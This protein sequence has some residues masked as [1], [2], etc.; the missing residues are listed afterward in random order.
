LGTVETDVPETSVAAGE[1]SLL[2]HRA[3]LATLVALTIASGTATAWVAAT[4]PKTL[5]PWVALM[6]AA[7]AWTFRRPR[8][9]DL[10]EPFTFLSWTHYAPAFVVG[11]GL[12]A[13]G[14]VLYPYPSIVAN[15]TGAV[16]LTLA[17]VSIAYL[18]LGAGTRWRGAQALGIRL[19]RLLPAPRAERTIPLLAIIVLIVIGTAANYGAFRAGVIGFAVPRAPGPLDAAVSYAGLFTTLGHFLFW[20]RWFA[21]DQDRLPRLA[22]LLPAFVVI[23]T[24]V[25]LGN[26]GALLMQFLVSALAFRLARG[27]LTVGQ[28]IVV[29]LLAFMALGIGM[30]Y[31]S[32]FRQLRGGESGTPAVAAADAAALRDSAAV[33]PSEPTPS[34]PPPVPAPVASPPIATPPVVPPAAVSPTPV[35]PAP[36]VIAPVVTPQTAAATP[37]PPS[38][39]RHLEVAADTAGKLIRDPLSTPFG[40][41]L[42]GVGQRLNIVSDASVT[43]A[44]YPTL[45]SFEP[46]YGIVNIWTMTWS[47]FVPRVLWPGKPRVSDAR[48]YS[49][50]YFGHDKNSYATTPPVDLIRN[51][52]PY[53]MP[54]GMALLGV[55]LGAL[56]TALMA[57]AGAGRSERAALFALLLVNISPEGSF[58]LILPTMFRVGLVVVAGLALVRLIGAQMGARRATT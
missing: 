40:R 1:S 25:I 57:P 22:L 32:L 10:F 16:A 29:V 53:G 42:V 21:P 56:G 45:H 20:F 38:L 9:V 11:S 28:G 27:R 55:W 26:R 43:I 12:L 2:S 6:A 19:R 30:V 51:V 44:R 49:S 39:E 58:G 3:T 7:V 18:A 34:P 37:A 46:D 4:N 36:V 33:R 35:A 5:Y 15:P 54:L 23:S 31:G 52:G 48:A 14:V 41:I 13:A 8:K 24:M 50:L 17:Y 47:G